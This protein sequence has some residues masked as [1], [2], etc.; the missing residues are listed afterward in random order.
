MLVLISD[1]I[2]CFPEMGCW[3]V[4]KIC[5]FI[6]T[7][8]NF[9]QT[10][11]TETKLTGWTKTA[12]DYTWKGKT[13]E[14][15]LSWVRNIQVFIYSKRNFWENFFKSPSPETRLHACVVQFLIAQKTKITVWVC[16]YCLYNVHFFISKRDT[17]LLWV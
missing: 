11:K 10:T 1:F 17:K 13:I 5:F 14:T 7:R 8:A 6:F 3:Y 15:N 16:G 12:L 2:G 4:I 9:E